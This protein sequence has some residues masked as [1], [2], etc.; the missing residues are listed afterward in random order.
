MTVLAVV[1][2]MKAII[3]FLL[4]AIKEKEPDFRKGD[5]FIK[6]GT[7]FL[8]LGEKVPLTNFFH[9]KGTSW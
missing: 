9:F 6:K 3:F 7:F 5:C 4:V 2:I 1:I 8:V